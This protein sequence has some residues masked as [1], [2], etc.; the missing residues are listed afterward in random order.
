[1]WWE[2]LLSHE[3][4]ENK[5]DNNEIAKLYDRE[6]RELKTWE[7]TEEQYIKNQEALW[8]IE[9]SLILFEDKS[10]FDKALFIDYLEITNYKDQIYSIFL[11][12]SSRDIKKYIKNNGYIINDELFFRFAGNF[13]VGISNWKKSE[14]LSTKVDES[15]DFLNSYSI[16][17]D[18]NLTNELYIV[19]QIQNFIWEIQQLLKNTELYEWAEG[20]VVILDKIFASPEFPKFLDILRNID[21]EK[22]NEGSRIWLYQRFKSFSISV[23]PKYNSYFLSYEQKNNIRLKDTP[24]KLLQAQ[25][26]GWL[27]WTEKPWGQWSIYT[28]KDDKGNIISIDVSQNPPKRFLSNWDYLLETDFPIENL[29][30]S[31]EKFERYKKEKAPE[32]EEYNTQINSIEWILQQFFWEDSGDWEEKKEAIKNILSSY[33]INITDID[34]DSFEDAKIS[35]QGLLEKK[36]EKLNDLQKKIENKYKSYLRDEVNKYK[37]SI[38]EKDEKQK[39]TLEFLHSIWFDLIPQRFTEQLFDEINSDIGWLRGMI[40]LGNGIRLTEDID[41]KN[42]EFWSK[43]TQNE[44][45]VFMRF[46]NK[47]VSGDSEE[48]LNIDTFLSWEKDAQSDRQKLIDAFKSGGI[49]NENGSFIYRQMRENLKNTKLEKSE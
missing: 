41:L 4:Q 3:Q 22:W 46:F 1:M 30:K 35:F 42:G 20:L 33:H 17:S 12:Q 9:S 27:L 26:I 16:F 29:Y 28:A 18:A 47:L 25:I 39:Q 43:D 2:Q 14:I 38:Q 45:E 23:S 49:M 8:K 36:K 21:K 40:D 7:I 31:V 19:P 48:P 15:K 24:S 13:W 32:L 37:K 11:E 44:R 5:K 10:G 6:K 34:F